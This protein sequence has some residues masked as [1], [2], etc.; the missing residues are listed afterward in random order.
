MIN[1]TAECPLPAMYYYIIM[2]FRV[3]CEAIGMLLRDLESSFRYM[4]P[5]QQDVC[6]VE[7]NIMQ[8]KCVYKGTNA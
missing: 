6:A 4:L 7:L 5:W 8:Y 2:R 3:T 1:A